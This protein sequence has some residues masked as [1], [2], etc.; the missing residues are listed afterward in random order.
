MVTNA[1]YSQL[2]GTTVRNVCRWKAKGAPLH[3]QALMADWIEH[4]KSRRGVNK[5]ISKAE[6]DLPAP[7]ERPAATMA[8]TIPLDLAVTLDAAPDNDLVRARRIEKVAARIA[9]SGDA[10]AIDAWAKA[11]AEARRLEDQARKTASSVTEGDRILAEVTLY[12]LT[13]FMEGL[14]KLPE[15]AAIV[16]VGSL[17]KDAGPVIEKVQGYI[18]GMFSLLLEDL[19][20]ST[21]GTALASL[22]PMDEEGE[23]EWKRHDRE[24]PNLLKR[25]PNER[26]AETCLPGD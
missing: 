15:Y 23:Q 8:E 19:I 21:R 3:D 11:S 4:Q 13:R 6:A 26:Q 16:S 9:E 2:Y 25:P 7:I 17:Q 18:D 10:K 12:V 22:F 1:E 14:E 20:H 24:H 5:F